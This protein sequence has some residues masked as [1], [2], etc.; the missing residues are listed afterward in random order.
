MEQWKEVKD[1]EK[2]Q[3][4]NY[5][6]FRSTKTGVPVIKEI[7]ATGHGYKLAFMSKGR[8][9]DVWQTNL[10]R[11]IATAFIPNPENKP[12]V[13]HIDGN[14]I[15]NRVENLEWCTH[16]ENTRHAYRIGLLH[17]R[18]NKPVNQY[19]LNNTLIRKFS[20]IRE[21]KK[22][23]GLDATGIGRCARGRQIQYSGFIWKFATD[24]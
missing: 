17:S 1:Y 8:T 2:Y 5:G 21:A 3:V 10:H 19:D 11:L 12:C 18:F 6:R 7:N 16:S 4:S 22:E 14:K 24:K 20:S 9:E 13:N 15:N 23:T